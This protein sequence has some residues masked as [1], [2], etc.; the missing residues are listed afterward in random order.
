MIC[1]R[2]LDQS[3]QATPTCCLLPWIHGALQ[4]HNGSVILDPWFHEAQL[5]HTGLLFPWGSTVSQWSFASM[6]LCCVRMLS[7]VPRDCTMTHW[8]LGSMR[9]QSVTMV[10]VIPYSPAVSQWPLGCPS[11]CGSQLPPTFFLEALQCHRGLLGTTV[12]GNK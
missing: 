9:L 2:H 12:S 5:C 10:S 6:K 1:Q 4:C 11:P 8:P 7:L 3:G